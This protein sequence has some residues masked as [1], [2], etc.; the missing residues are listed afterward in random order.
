MGLRTEEQ[1]TRYQTTLTIFIIVLASP[2]S[3]EAGKAGTLL[4]HRG[5]ALCSGSLDVGLK[6]CTG[7]LPDQG[8]HAL[9]QSI[10]VKKTHTC[11]AILGDD[12]QSNRR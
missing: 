9:G 1:Q 4:S 12:K 11:L 6:P 7:R 2:W 5:F 3:V 10:M 8:S